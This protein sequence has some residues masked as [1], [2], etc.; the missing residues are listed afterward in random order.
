MKRRRGG[1]EVKGVK[2]A[3]EEEETHLSRTCVFVIEIA[4]LA[5]G[6]LDAISVRLGA[7]RD[8]HK[9]ESTS[10][11]RKRGPTL[12]IDRGPPWPLP[13]IARKAR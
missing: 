12:R 4:I 5:S 13:S 3:K 2:E 7:A 10:R 9:S 1:Q 11:K 8:R 6:I